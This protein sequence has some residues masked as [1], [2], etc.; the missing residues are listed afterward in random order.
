LREQLAAV[1]TVTERLRRESRGALRRP[2][3]RQG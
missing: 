1:E 3:S 2:S